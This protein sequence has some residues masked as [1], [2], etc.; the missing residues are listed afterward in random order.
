MIVPP[1]VHAF[2]LEYPGLTNR[3]I[4]DLHIFQA[5]DPDDHPKGPP[6]PPIKVKALWDT[7]ATSSVITKETAQK[8]CLIPINTV[9]VNHAGG[10]SPANAYMV[11][12]YLPNNVG[13][14]MLQV[15]ECPGTDDSFGAIIGM[16]IICRGDFSITNT[17]GKTCVNFC[18]PAMHNYNFVNEL[19]EIGTLKPEAHPKIG[20]NDLCPC[21]KLNSEGR[22][23]K[24]K[25]C[26]GKTN[27]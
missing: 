3:I 2:R 5:F 22:R 14:P 9:N 13:V 20:R 23:L 15:I 1:R 8:L 17:E 18:L 7:G 10:T 11:N 27:M 25:R 19:K 6:T 21:G 24:Y 12:V 26:C 16:D 4:T